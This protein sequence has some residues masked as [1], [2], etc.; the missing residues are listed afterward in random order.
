MFA[1]SMHLY[2]FGLFAGALNNT[3]ILLGSTIKV[4]GEVALADAF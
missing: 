3:G 2:Q 4:H 1:N